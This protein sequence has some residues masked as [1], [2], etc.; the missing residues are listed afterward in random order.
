M[1][2]CMK[3][4]LHADRETVH[5]MNM[6]TE[7][8]SRYRRNISNLRLMPESCGEKALA[9]MRLHD[10]VDPWTTVEVGRKF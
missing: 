1:L 10:S 6:N 2:A 8:S 9:E 7:Q 4:T 3:C 5:D